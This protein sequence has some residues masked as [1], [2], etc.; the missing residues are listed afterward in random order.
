MAL[1]TVLAVFLIAFYL[2]WR[3]DDTLP[4]TLP[5]V[6]CAVGLA[7]YALAFLRAMLWIDLL[8][9]L[10][11]AGVV[12][13]MLRQVRREGSKSLTRAARRLLL[14]PYLWCGLALIL[15]M[16]FFLREEQI[17]EWDGYNF[18]GPDTKSLYFWN[19][20]APKHANTAPIFG[21]YPPM[22]QLIWWWGLHLAGEY[23]ERYIFY[24]YY[25]FGAILLLSVADRFRQKGAPWQAPVVCVAAILLPGTACT[26]WY[27]ALWVDPLMSMLFGVAL[28][29]VVCRSDRHPGF[30]K[31]KLL[32]CVLCLTL[33][34]AIG[35]LWSLLALLFCLL[36]WWERRELRFP[37]AGLAGCLALFGSWR[38]FCQVMERSTTLVNNFSLQAAQRLEE[39]SQGV[40][41]T[42]GNNK[43]YILSY[44]K[45]FF[46]TPI[47]RESTWAI[48]LS[49][50]ALILLLFLGAV[51]LWRFGFFPK[52]K[53]GRLLG[54]M[55]LSLALIYS[56]LFIGHLTMF[57]HEPQYLEPVSSVT[58]MTRYCA[59]ANMGLLILL[60]TLAS[61]Q[62]TR[63]NRLPQKR[64]TA[65]L[66]LCA[67]VL[68]SCGA[69]REMGRR[70]LYDPLD[71][72]RIQF[73]QGLREVYGDFLTAT[74][75]I[76]LRQAP[77]RV[78]LGIY[79]TQT[80]PIVINEASPVSFL[81][82]FLSE[83]P[84]GDLRAIESALDRGHERYLYLMGCCDGLKELL[85]A[86]TD[87][88]SPFQTRTLYVIDREKGLTLTRLGQK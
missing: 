4:G 42:S 32:V 27:R 22:S 24:A 66:A 73:R 74:Q 57:Y 64:Q 45:A 85:S 8:L 17:L 35:L 28:S 19:G 61:G 34:K 29:L 75:D 56:A 55:G 70:F 69:Y 68:F 86:H 1:L 88:G 10:C 23:Q 59:P 36:W 9:L 78:L 18:W 43:G 46:L 47:H 26:A 79:G 52:R 12:F 71:A 53:L 11:G 6:I 76:P 87:D 58:L 30:W 51:A 14:D 48:D 31:A 77:G 81:T 37:L 7:L 60:V 54:F 15:V 3:F 21:D 13:V 44:W 72:Q 2:A 63:P 82:V 50:A 80:N 5:T 67:L 84:E 38:L 41:W 62:G 20:F 16:L 49:P 65:A 25:A 83:Y 39:L 40:F 33:V